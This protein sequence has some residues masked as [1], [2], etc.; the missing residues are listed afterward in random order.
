ML[1]PDVRSGN[2]ATAIN[3][4]LTLWNQTEPYGNGTLTDLQ[5]LGY[6]AAGV[7]IEL[8]ELLSTTDGI[9]CYVYE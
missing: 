8:G 7:E 1:D 9:F 6:A 3:G 2:V 5:N 4:P